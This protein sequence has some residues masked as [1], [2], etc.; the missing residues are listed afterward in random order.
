MHPKK[1]PQLALEGFAGLGDEFQLTFVGDG[2]LRGALESVAAQLGVAGRVHFAGNVT[3]ASRYTAAFDA[4]VVASTREEAFGMA[5]LEAMVA[6]VPAVCADVPGPRSVLGR[7]GLYFSDDT[8]VSVTA[9]LRRC[10][11]L[12]PHERSALLQ[13]QRRRAVDL[14]SVEAVAAR[15]QAL[16]NMDA[17]RLPVAS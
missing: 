5:L 11:A 2:A 15:Y 13:M 8:P 14:F 3:D 10:A 7:E 6:G 9:A 16:L 1:R 17:T 4:V 12:L